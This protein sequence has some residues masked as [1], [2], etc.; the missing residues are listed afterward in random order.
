MPQPQPPPHDLQS[1]NFH[2]NNTNTGI[3]SSLASSKRSLRPSGPQLCPDSEEMLPTFHL[4]DAGLLV[5][6]ADSPLK[7]T[8]THRLSIQNINS[9]SSLCFPLKYYK[10]GF[11]HLLTVTFYT[12]TGKLQALD[13]TLRQNLQILQESSSKQHSPVCLHNNPFSNTGSC[14]N[15]LPVDRIKH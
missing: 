10:P 2:A 9:P 3:P 7:L 14:P 13:S 4:G 8:K 1:C 5:I 6:S 12:P 15:L 11:H